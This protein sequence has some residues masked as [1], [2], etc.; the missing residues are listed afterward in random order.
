[1]LFRHVTCLSPWLDPISDGNKKALAV[2][3]SGF[4]EF[5]FGRIFFW[6]LL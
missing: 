4:L 6:S 1:M 3:V 2:S 5:F